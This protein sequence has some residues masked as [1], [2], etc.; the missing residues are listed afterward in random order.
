MTRIAWCSDTHL[1]NHQF[2]GGALYGGLNARAREGLDTLRRAVQLAAE[3]E[4]RAFFVLGDLFD[5][6]RPPPPLIAAVQQIFEWGRDVQ[7]I[8]DFVLLVGNHDRASSA[9]GDHALAPLAPVARV[10]ERPELVEVC[11]VQVFCWPY[12][13]GQEPLTGFAESDEA[14][15]RLSSCPKL[16][17]MHA[18]IRDKETPPWLA[19][20]GIHVDTVRERCAALGAPLALAGDWHTYRV[21]PVARQL[22]TLIPAGFD[23]KGY[24]YGK[25]IVTKE[26]RVIS[27]RSVPGP[28]FVDRVGP[29]G[30]WDKEF[31]I[32]V[33]QTCAP[34]EEAAVRITLHELVQ[35]GL[36]RGFRVDVEQ[37]EVVAAARSAAD[38]A[39]SS[40]SLG[41]AVDG[42]MAAT[43][44]DAG[45]DRQAVLGRVREYLKL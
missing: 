4:C 3:Y 43:P 39:R 42:Y 21:F 7:G 15:A 12:M 14:L 40:K 19:R 11:G 37:T 31:S 26:D 34:A 13:P 9:P 24:S 1:W 10:V 44:L 2:C 17:A 25:L 28:R 45:V 41:E 20:S 36:Y 16:V 27:V 33:R 32:Y 8:Q 6:P 35:Q 29:T 22:G 38:A 30:P 18:G 5:G 23:D